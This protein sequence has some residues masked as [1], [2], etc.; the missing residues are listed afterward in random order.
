MPYSY[1]PPSYGQGGSVTGGESFEER[2]KR[3]L[4]MIQRRAGGLGQMF[5]QAAGGRG[6]GALPDAFSAAMQ[7]ARLPIEDFPGLGNGRREMLPPGVFPPG[8]VNPILPP[9][10]APPFQPGPGNPVGDLKMPMGP[11]SPIG[12]G[13][14]GGPG[15][16]PQPITPFKVNPFQPSPR[17]G[18][19]GMY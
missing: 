6:Y 3:L 16:A 10:F 5:G 1:T 15:P 9:G 8:M 12:P 7:G 19:F 4:E 17:Q 14:P 18:P 13:L 11:T 2:K